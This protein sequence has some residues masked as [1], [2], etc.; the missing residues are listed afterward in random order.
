MT[1][2]TLGVAVVGSLI[3]AAPATAQTQGTGTVAISPCV[4]NRV[5]VAF[6]WTGGPGSTGMQVNVDNQGA[7]DTKAQLNTLGDSKFVPT[8]GTYVYEFILAN[9]PH[10]IEARGYGYGR[11]VEGSL[12]VQCGEIPTRVVEVAGPERVVEVAGPE[13]VVTRTVTRRVRVLARCRR[14]RATKGPKK[15]KVVL[16][17]PRTRGKGK[18]PGTVQR[19]AFTG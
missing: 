10:V 6:D 8:P 13:R 19:P 12:Q 2:R 14:V 17:C 4:D 1:I 11:W 3:L 16:A 7:Q 15:G 5:T 18:K 9:G